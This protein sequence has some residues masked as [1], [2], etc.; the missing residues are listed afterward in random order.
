MSAASRISRAQ[1]FKAALL[2]VGGLAVADVVIAEAPPPAQ[3]R[4]SATQD[5]A[6]LNFA[7]LL[8]YVQGGLYAEALRRGALKGELRQF[9]EVVG[10]HER[11]HAAFLRQALGAAAR[12]PP[13]LDFGDDAGNAT[14]FMAASAKLEDLG[15]AALNSQAPNLTSRALNAAARIVSVEARHAA[16]IRDLRGEVPAPFATEPQTTA[17]RV[18]TTLQGT[19]YVK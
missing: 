15:V 10:A 1:A 9:A 6:I 17:R 2:A 12:R 19:G 16:W 14:R 13:K 11:A 5:V 3:S 8:E 7:L 4:A 18:V